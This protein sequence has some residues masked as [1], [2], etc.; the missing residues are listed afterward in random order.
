MKTLKSTFEF[1]TPRERFFVLVAVII[2]VLLVAFD[3]AGIFLVG[4]VVSLISGTVIASTSPLSAILVW[5]N[6]H[7]YQD[8][9]VVLA[10][11]AIVFFI[12]KGLLSVVLSYLTATYV[13]RIEAAKASQVYE[14]MVRAPLNRV[15]KFTSQDALHGLTTSMNSAFASS[16]NIG[17]A[18]VGEIALLIGVSSYLAY[19]NFWLFLGVACFFGV[20]GLLMQATIGRGSS[21]AAVKAHRGQLETH[22]SI[23]NTLNNFRQVAASSSLVPFAK[24]FRS[25]RSATAH[26]NAVYATFTTLP[27][28]ITEISVMIGV[29]I[30]VIQRSGSGGGVSSATI[31]VFLAGIFRIVASMLP[32]QAGLSSLKR[33]TPEAELAFSLLREFGQILDTEPAQNYSAGAKTLDVKNL[34]FRY[35]PD[36]KT[37]LK[38]VSFSV[39]AGAYVAVT[40]KSGGGKSTLADLILGL[41]HPEHGVLLVGGENPAAVRA[42]RRGAIGYVPQSTH[43]IPGTLVENIL[44]EVRPSNVDHQL[45]S[46]VIKAAGLEDVLEQL[47]NGAQTVIGAGGIDLSGGQTQ[48]VGLARALYQKP[49]ILVLDEATS[50]LD[51]ETELLIHRALLSMRNK[52]TLVVIAHRPQT[53]SDADY[54]LRVENGGA[55]LSR[56]P[57]GA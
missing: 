11:V 39:P 48:R 37:V 16:I 31:A 24:Q 40:G 33:V 18:M 9:Y 8:G 6:H 14:G 27:R 1:L 21:S 20:V 25:T 46:S 32:L 15:E 2:R 42:A 52:V 43:L 13:A 54:F 44:L 7:G 38:G 30:L 10:A 22:G 5:L 29:G 19:V 34:T 3:L 51:G 49:D 45:L 55:T 57:Q 53:L 26:Q 4:V 41:R 35:G 56:T 28:Y 36:S 12:A 47:P 23:L 17:A 50:A